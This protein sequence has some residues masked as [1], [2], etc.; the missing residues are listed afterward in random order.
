MKIQILLALLLAAASATICT[1][2]QR[3]FYMSFPTLSKRDALT[4]LF[5]TIDKNMTALENNYTDSAL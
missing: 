3:S 5:M 2:P 1:E 4:N